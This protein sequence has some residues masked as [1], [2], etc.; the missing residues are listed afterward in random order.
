MPCLTGGSWGV[1][2]GRNDVKLPPLT[3]EVL[4]A[5]LDFTVAALQAIESQLVFHMTPAWDKRL[6]VLQSLYFAL[7]EN[8]SRL[9]DGQEVLERALA[10]FRTVREELEKAK[11][12]ME[13]HQT[14]PAKGANLN[15]Y[16]I[17]N[18]LRGTSPIHMNFHKIMGANLM[19]GAPFFANLLVHEAT[20]KYCKTDDVEVETQAG[21]KLA[22]MSTVQNLWKL[23]N[24]GDQSDPEKLRLR[25][26]GTDGAALTTKGALNNAD[27][28]SWFMQGMLEGLPDTLSVAL[29]F[30][31]MKR[32]LR[33]AAAAFEAVQREFFGKQADLATYYQVA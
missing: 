29:K 21:T 7:P 33:A 9:A 6:A 18:A 3:G 8:K 19:M 11:G 4:G 32:D 14:D 25:I 10:V 22:Y 2:V 1:A 23:W 13:I 24:E 15:G 12:E 31:G 30:G 5:T 27:S 20:H 16:V 28:F 26:V 17:H